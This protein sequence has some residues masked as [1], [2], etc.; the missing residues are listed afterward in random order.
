ME[1]LKNPHGKFYFSVAVD[2]SSAFTLQQKIL[3]KKVKADIFKKVK[4]PEA[5]LE[6]S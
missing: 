1:T 2:Q 3:R 5:Y 6:L 4:K